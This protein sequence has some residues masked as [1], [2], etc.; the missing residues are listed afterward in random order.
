MASFVHAA[1][2]QRMSLKFCKDY[3]V[4]Q[5]KVSLIFAGEQTTGMVVVVRTLALCPKKRSSLPAIRHNG[6]H[7]ATQPAR[8]FAIDQYSASKTLRKNSNIAARF[9][10]FLSFP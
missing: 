10:T 7:V 2:L 9:S 8:P 1:H 6:G 5:K 4:G 3:G